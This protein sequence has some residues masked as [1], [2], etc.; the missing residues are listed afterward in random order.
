[1]HRITRTQNKYRYNL[2]VISTR[3]M[4]TSRDHCGP[5]QLPNP[6]CN[7]TIRCSFHQHFQ[8]LQALGANEMCRLAWKWLIKSPQ[9]KYFHCT[10]SYDRRTEILCP[11]TPL[12]R[13]FPTLKMEVISSP[14]TLVHMLITWRYSPED[15]NFSALLKSVEISI[16]YLKNAGKQHC[17]GQPHNYQ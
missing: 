8:A 7:T 9:F 14:E 10:W 6:C 17:D 3:L 16:R 11:A 5:Q 13:W 1:M 2:G 15:D 4:S 12:A